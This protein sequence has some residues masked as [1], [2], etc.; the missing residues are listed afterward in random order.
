MNHDSY[1]DEYISEILREVR[2]VAL[3]GASTNP[4]RPSNMVMRFLLSHGYE[5]HPVNPGLEGGDIHGREA[6][7]RLP[8][9]P[10]PVDTVDIFRNSAAALE[11]TRAAIR[12]KDQL[13]IK[14]VWMQQGVRNDEAAAEAEA[15][16]LKVV[17]NRCPKI[18]LG[19]LAHLIGRT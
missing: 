7:A 8:D 15:A 4:A 10:A 11:V 3:I 18:E 9:V 16:G 5:V 1:S 2:T 6:Y 14:V 12:F 19:R 13:Q 17:M